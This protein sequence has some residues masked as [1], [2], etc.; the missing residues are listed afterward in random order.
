[1]KI[2]SLLL[3]VGILLS[4]NAVS[5]AQTADEIIGKYLETIGGVD[6]WKDFQSMRVTGTAIQSGVNYP[7]TVTSMRPNLQ[8]VVADVMGKQFIEAYDGE[9]AWGLNPFTG[10]TEPQKKTDEETKEAAM[11]NFESDFIDYRD[12]GYSVT[13][14]DTEEIEGAKCFKL[15]LVKEEGHEE[16]HF[17]DAENYVPIMTRNF[18]Q[19]GQMKG[20]AIETY[21]SDYQEVEGSGVVIAYTMEQR[22]NGQVV[23]QMVN[24]KVEFNPEDLTK[25]SFAFPEK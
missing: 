3:A 11:R 10:A 22:F 21:F 17:I 24:E 23:M 16:Y 8:K 2:K 25:E 5:H 19:T 4:A 14:E 13:L 15:K 7:F 20:Q 18:I 6:N 9:S 12:K 1:M